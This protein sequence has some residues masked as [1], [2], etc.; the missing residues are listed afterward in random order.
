[1]LKKPEFRDEK[2]ARCFQDA[3]VVQVYHHRPPYPD[4]V[5]DKLAYLVDPDVDALLDV[6]TGLGEIARRMA[7][8]VGRVDAVDFSER[9]IARAKSL[10]GG[11]HPGITWT[12]S[13]VET[14]PVTGPYGLITA[15][16][17]LHW[18]DLNVAM[19]RFARLLSPAGYLAVVERDWQT[20]IE[21][22]DIVAEYSTNRQYFPWDLV[23]AIQESG[24]FERVGAVD[25]GCTPWY[26][27]V[28]E[29][30]DCRHSQ[31]GLSRDGMGAARA[32][33]FDGRVRRRIERQAAEGTVKLI[34]GRIQGTCTGEVVWGRPTP[35]A[36]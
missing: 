30:L 3:G 1:M 24:L 17:C 34:D 8:R 9:M 33:A 22:R 35:A 2:Y 20:G 27:T 18:F 25:A 31:N 10:P 15:A 32:S 11:D 12:V 26:P 29:Y 21:D 4:E 14:A 28:E 16:G 6:G 13:H 36:S 19:P 23:N 5:Y 7:A